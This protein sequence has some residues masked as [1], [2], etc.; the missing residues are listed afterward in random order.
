MT[1]AVDQHTYGRGRWAAG[2]LDVFAALPGAAAMDMIRGRAYARE[3]RVEQLRIEPGIV[4]ALVRDD[5]RAQPYPVVLTVPVLNDA[6]WNRLLDALGTEAGHS[7]ALLD[8]QPPADG[9]IANAALPSPGELRA[10]CTCP[11]RDRQ[12]CRHSAG[13]CY[14]AA[15]AI[16]ADPFVLLL[17]RGRAKEH[18]LSALREHR[19]PA[20]PSFTSEGRLATAAYRT[21]PAPLP[22]VAPLPPGTR[23]PEVPA[24]PIP[25]PPAVSGLT[26]AELTEL[27]QRAAR[28]ARSLLAEE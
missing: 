1:D 27:A 24:T 28:A 4:S 10:V 18:V 5:E 15:A 25:D 17:L 20:A 3:G 6:A 2:W 11:Q 22:P 12:P 23:H 8:G 13:L 7:A 21:A 26:A 14:E 16:D 9:E 19:D